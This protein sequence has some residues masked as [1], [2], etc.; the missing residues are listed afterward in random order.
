[1]Y[2]IVSAPYRLWCLRCSGRISRSQSRPEFSPKCA[3]RNDNS[4]KTGGNHVSPSILDLLLHPTTDF[5]MR[6]SSFAAESESLPSRPDTTDI[7][8]FENTFH[9]R[10]ASIP[11]ISSQSPLLSKRQDDVCTNTFGAGWIRSTCSP[12]K[13]LC[14]KS[15]LLDPTDSS[16]RRPG[17]NEEQSYPQCQQHLSLGWCCTERYVLCPYVDVRIY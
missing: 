15:I 11:Q 5:R 1:M 7:D 17:V 10:L 3:A 8:S 4:S 9:P 2:S 13:T 12:G 16:D 14:C 6:W